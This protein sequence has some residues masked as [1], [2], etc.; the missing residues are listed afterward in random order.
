MTG[1]PQAP[2]WEENAYRF[3]SALERREAGSISHACQP[4]PGVLQYSPEEEEILCGEVAAELLRAGFTPIM[5]Y[6]HPAQEGSE[7]NYGCGAAISFCFSTSSLSRQHLNCLG[8]IRAVF[9]KDIR[10]AYSN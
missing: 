6:V 4:Y 5:A 1:E 9:L 3:L 8:R 2:A 10:R 7:E